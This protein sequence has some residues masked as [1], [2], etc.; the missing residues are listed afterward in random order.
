MLLVAAFV[1]VLVTAPRPLRL[2]ATYRCKVIGRRY[3]NP[4]KEGKDLA[5]R[6]V[7]E[8]CGFESWCQQRIFSPEI[9]VKVCLSCTCRSDE[10]SA[11]SKSTS[12][13]FHLCLKLRFSFSFWIDHLIQVSCFL[14]DEICSYPIFSLW[15]KKNI[16]S[17]W[18]CFLNLLQQSFFTSEVETKSELSKVGWNAKE[19]SI[20]GK[21][22]NWTFV[23]RNPFCSLAV[24]FK[25]QR[26][27]FLVA[28]WKHLIR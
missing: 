1:V 16:D 14:M 6:Q 26:I 13:F 9:S 5:R 23:F 15:M 7:T 11:K 25:V 19:A 21:S 22:N 28:C 4:C 10:N 20:G 27:I 17:C 2:L 8:G 12:W 24:N 3:P 18:G